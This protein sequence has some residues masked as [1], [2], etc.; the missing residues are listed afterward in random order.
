L[1][2]SLRYLHKVRPDVWVVVVLFLF[3]FLF[4]LLS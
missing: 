4:F 2:K 3:L 1:K